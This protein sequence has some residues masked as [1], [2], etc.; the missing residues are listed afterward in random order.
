MEKETKAKEALEVAQNKIGESA[1]ELAK[2]VQEIDAI[3]DLADPSKDVIKYE[4]AN[5]KEQT[6]IEMLAKEIDI[7][8]PNSVIFFGSK[9]QEHINTIAESMLE[10][11]Q[12]KDI[13]TAGD[14]LNNL[15]AAIKGFDI[16]GLN[17]NMK[18]GFFSKMLGLASPAVKFMGKY[19]DVKT[20]IDHII[21]SLELQK[22]QLLVDIE[23]LDKLY[24][25]NFEYF[26]E[27][28][29]YIAAG[30]FKLKELDTKIIP[31][32]KKEAGTSKKMAKSLQLQDIVAT[33]ND[34]ER[35][36]HDLRLTRQVSMQALPS[37]RIVQESDKNIISKINSTIV[38]TVP[39][40]KN[41]LAQTV[42]IY[43]TAEAA[44]SIKNANDLTND[45]LAE[46]AKNLK[47][48][49]KAVREEVER[50]VY[51]IETIKEANQTLID[52]INESLE[53]THRGQEARK[54]AEKE[55]LAIEKQLSDALIAAGTKKKRK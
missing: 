7:K 37:I 33:R 35:R 12:N 26:K 18:Q 30:A 34:L 40:W 42:T 14:S 50:G 44:K 32:I 48:A 25:V 47:A 45:L 51:D 9:A 5:T 53:I 28:E 17:P 23:T 8:D 1:K 54:E 27:L 55:L 29:V 22:S 21:D 6:Y 13:G 49:N 38:N 10:G 36:V 3:D 41:Q 4:N 15:V 2:T 19:E 52:T 39:L 43:R 20:Q 16:D 11:V 24:D 46:N 31:Q